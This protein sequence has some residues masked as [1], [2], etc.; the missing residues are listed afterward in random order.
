MSFIT[1]FTCL[2]S[3]SASARNIGPDNFG[4]RASDEVPFLWDQLSPDEGG[5]ASNVIGQLDWV[6]NPDDGSVEIQIGFDFRQQN[7][8]QTRIVERGRH[9]HSKGFS[10]TGRCD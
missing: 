7:F 10:R 2:F 8:G 6:G 9:R 4:Y 3:L 1:I 5:T